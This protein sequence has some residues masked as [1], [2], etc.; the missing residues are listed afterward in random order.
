MWLDEPSSELRPLAST[1]AT[2]F[3]SPTAVIVHE[4]VQVELFWFVHEHPLHGLLGA[5]WSGGGSMIDVAILDWP[6]RVEALN[7]LAFDRMDP[8]TGAS[9]A[10]ARATVSA[11]ASA[12]DG[13]LPAGTLVVDRMV[14]SRGTAPILLDIIS[15]VVV[16][17]MLHGEPS[18]HWLIDATRR[19]ASEVFAE[20]RAS[21]SVGPSG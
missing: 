8:R 12:A 15:R 1:N 11:I 19:Y 21:R 7:S 2:V 17:A 6:L 18:C 3:G 14:E 16:E 5:T 4:S 20:D 10:T 13:R 9:A